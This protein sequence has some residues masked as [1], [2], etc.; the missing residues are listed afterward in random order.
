MSITMEAVLK[1]LEPDEP[2][3]DKAASL[4]PDAL[5][6]LRSLVQG[7]DPMLA[8]KAAYAASLLEGDQGKDVVAAA[9]QS[10]TASVRV[11]AAAAANNLP[12]E[13]AAEV[14]MDLVD[15]DDSGVRKV[16]LSSVPADAPPQLSEKVESASGRAEGTGRATG[17]Q[18]TAGEGTAAQMPGEGQSMMPQEKPAAG[19]M[20]GEKPNA[21]G[22]AQGKGLMPGEKA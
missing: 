9:A 7:N 2:N 19:L 12:S 17:E 3:Y 22:D 16:A 10:E 11:A 21:A 1:V 15:D 20:P 6:H 4:G 14:L 18:G 13:S 5:P 8:A